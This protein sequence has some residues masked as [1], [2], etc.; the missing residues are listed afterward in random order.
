MPHA[1]AKASRCSWASGGRA[2]FANQVPAA[3]MATMPAT[4][5]SAGAAYGRKKRRCVLSTPRHHAEITMSPVM[6]NRMRTSVIVSSRRGWSNPF[7]STVVIEGASAIPTRASTPAAS[8]NSPRIAPARARAGPLSGRSLRAAYTGMNDA[9]SVPSPS[10]LR[11]VLGIR[12]A[13]RNASA[14][15]LSLPK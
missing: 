2:R 4:F 12:S 7:A 8:N 5:Q 1:S 15:T 6:G 14:G 13:A 11:S 10:R 3:S 9:S